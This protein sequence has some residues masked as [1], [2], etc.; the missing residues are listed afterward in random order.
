MSS[1]LPLKPKFCYLPSWGGKYTTWRGKA[2]RLIGFSMGGSSSLPKAVKPVWTKQ[3][4]R[5]PCSLM[6]V[7]VSQGSANAWIAITVEALSFP[8]M[9]HVVFFSAHRITA[10]YFLFWHVFFAL[11]ITH[12]PQGP[13]FLPFGFF[14]SGLLHYLLRRLWYFLVT[15]KAMI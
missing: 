12:W 7:N 10:G 6:Y 3:L 8:E 9:K 13:E 5:L 14:G 1:S 4:T 2:G 11:Q 15:R